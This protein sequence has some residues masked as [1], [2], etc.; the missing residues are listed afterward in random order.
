MAE[1]RLAELAEKMKDI[2]FAVLS[3]RTFL[4]R[5]ARPAMRVAFSA[6]AR[7]KMV[8]RCLS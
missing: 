3:T 8:T 2:D 1:K 4:S 5:L 7:V 6:G